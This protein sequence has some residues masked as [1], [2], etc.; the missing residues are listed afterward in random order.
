MARDAARG[1]WSWSLKL[2]VLENGVTPNGDALSVMKQ[3]A[4]KREQNIE[5]T[6]NTLTA[7]NALR[8]RVGFDSVAESEAETS[9]EILGDGPPDMP[10]PVNPDDAGE[11]LEF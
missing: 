9:K 4:F 3:Y 10:P 7:P 6:C 1:G 5:E 11:A 8:A 2:F